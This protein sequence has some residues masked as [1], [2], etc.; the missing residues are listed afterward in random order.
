MAF[1]K[2]KKEKIS[3][4]KKDLV[5]A[6]FQMKLEKVVNVKKQNA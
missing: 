2:I 4:R 5:W 1:K 3:L 6:Q